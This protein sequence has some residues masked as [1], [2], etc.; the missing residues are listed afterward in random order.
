M[1]KTRKKPPNVWAPLNF[2][3][4]G[5]PIKR[6]NTS[7]K[8]M[9][10]GRK[11]LNK[12]LIPPKLEIAFSQTLS[13]LSDTMVN[14]T[15]EA[16]LATQLRVSYMQH[17]YWG[18]EVRDRDK[19][20]EV[21]PLTGGGGCVSIQRS[22]GINRSPWYRLVGTQAYG[23]DVWYAG[24]LLAPI[25]LLSVEWVRALNWRLLLVRI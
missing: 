13:V 21:V 16:E 11:K 18:N 9:A 10:K 19:L 5:I 24:S 20:R 25:S 15:F 17:L 14:S 2:T 1:L 12:I 3:K 8:T 7:S 22:V 6:V 23:L 4:Q